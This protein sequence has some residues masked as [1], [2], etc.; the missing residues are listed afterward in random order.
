M[1]K[2]NSDVGS[3]V[4]PAPPAPPASKTGE[5]EDPGRP[6]RLYLVVLANLHYL[7][8]LGVLLGIAAGAVYFVLNLMVNSK[9][10]SVEAKIEKLDA[11][12]DAKIEKLDAK[13]DKLESKFDARFDTLE[14]KVTTL[15]ESQK[16]RDLVTVGSSVLVSI[17]ATSFLQVSVKQ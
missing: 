7:K 4:S 16:R 8:E 17:L 11:K 2:A 5:S 13:V 14:A 15:I 3:T 1:V 6:R 10:E 9:L 12:V